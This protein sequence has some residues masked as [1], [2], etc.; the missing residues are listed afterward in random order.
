MAK[1]TPTPAPLSRRDLLAAA[2]LASGAAA[3]GAAGCRESLEA[4]PGASALPV[5]ATGAPAAG[6]RYRMLG[7][8]G[9]RVSEIGVGAYPLDDPDVLL[10]AADHGINY[11]D[12]S[13]CYRGGASERAVGK[14]LKTARDRFVVTT[15]WCPHHIGQPPRK[16]V[17]LDMLDE[18][19][20]RLQTDHVDVVLN[21][22][23][24]RHSDGQGVE[25]LRN[26][27]MF[28]AFAAAKQAGKARFLG[29]SGHDGDLM[30][31]M[32]WAVSSGRFDVLLCRYSFLDYPEQQT[33]I[34]RAAQQNVGVVAMKTLAGAKGADLDKFRDR[35]ATFKQAALKWVLS[36]QRLSNLII[37]IASRRQVDEYAPA[38]G[39]AP[40]EADHAALAE[41]AALFSHEVC[42]FCNACEAACPDDVRIADVLR[43]SMYFHEYGQEQRG[44]EAYARLVAA[45]RGAH[46]AHCAGHCEAACGYDLPVK[47]LLLRARGALER[48]RG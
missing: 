31:V 23:V 43:F 24:G 14:A 12:T 7:R 36:N 33:L 19:L 15:K 4:E 44:R 20:R 13:H 11:V 47:T 3:L 5:P 28:D 26:E 38:S 16:Q 46:C 10:Y 27:E 18:S 30:S 40:G 9:L 35:H 2:A 39:A 6:M 21:H 25:R 41:Y 45:E 48:E 1:A 22:E 42:R 17:F 8:T 37:S 32:D 34:E 29:A